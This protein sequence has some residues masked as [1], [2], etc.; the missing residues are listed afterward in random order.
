MVIDKILKSFRFVLSNLNLYSK[1]INLLNNYK[2][3]QLHYQRNI[4]F[5][6][7]Q[8]A[9]WKSDGIYKHLQS[10]DN[11]KVSITIIPIWAKG[12]FLKEDFDQTRRYFKGRNYVIN[13]FSPKLP[14]K[15]LIKSFNNIDTVIFSDCWNLSNSNFYYYLLLF[16]VCFYIPYSHQVSKYGDYQAQ[17]NQL[18]HNFVKTIYAPHKLEFEIFRNFSHIR[19]QNVKLFGY[20]GVTKYI[21]AQ[22]DSTIAEKFFP[23]DP[24]VSFPNT[25]AKRVIWSPHHSINWSERKYSNFLEMHIQMLDLAEYYKSKINFVLKPHPM[26]KQTLYQHPSWGVEKTNGYFSEWSA[27]SNCRIDDGVYESLFYYSDALVHDCGSFIAEYTYLNKHHAFVLSSKEIRNSFN[28]FGQ[29]CL[30][31]TFNILSKNELY[32]FIEK[33]ISNENNQNELLNREF[34]QEI[35]DISSDSWKRISNDILAINN[36][37]Y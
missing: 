1:V 5:I 31:N 18:L 21:K 10:F 20:P 34:F 36:N 12:A 24:W 25:K 19:D 16:K 7:Y 9:V 35:N 13:D 11:V 29:R 23:E 37:D 6:V 22:K 8:S 17:Y 2:V 30:E 15:E 3:S 27:K 14:L 32:A 26:L 28:V 4:T 33:I